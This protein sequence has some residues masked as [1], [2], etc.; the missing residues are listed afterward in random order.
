MKLRFFV[1]HILPLLCVS[2]RPWNYTYLPS[3][4]DTEQVSK[5]QLWKNTWGRKD[6]FGN[7]TAEGLRIHGPRPRRGHT[8]VVI[9]TYLVMFGGRD[10]NLPREL[11]VPKTYNVKDINGV[12]EFTTYDKKPVSACLDTQGL[13]YSAAERASCTGNETRITIGR[14]YNDVWAYNMNCTRFFDGPCEGSGWEIW[15]PGSPNGG[16]SMEMGVL[17]CPMPSE[18][19][20]HKAVYF[21]DGVMYMYGGFSPRCG[22]YCDDLWMFDIYIK[23]WQQVNKTRELSR[24]PEFGDGFGNGGPGK[25]WRFTM[26]QDRPFTAKD[27]LDYQRFIVFGGHRLWEGFSPENSEGNNWS[28]YTTRPQGGYLNDL[29]IY[30]KKLD[31]TTPVGK[32]FRLS[33]GKWTRKTG[34]EVCMADPGTS[35]TQRND[36]SCSVTWPLGRAGHS[37]ALDHERNLMWIFGGYTTYFPYLTSNAPGAGLGTQTTKE[38]GYNPYPSHTYFLNDIWNFNFS[39]GQWTQIEYEVNDDV[40]EPR[41]DHIMLLR[42]EI[43]FVHGGQGDSTFFDDIWYFNLTVNKWLKKTR[44]VYPIY[45]SN[46]T[47]DI[48]FI[49]NPANNCTHLQWPKHLERDKYYPFDILP[50]AEQ[51]HYYPD[52]EY[53]PYWGIVNK[54][55]DRN[56]HSALSFKNHPPPYTPIVPYAAKGPMQ[57]ARKFVFTFNSTVNGTLYQWCTSVRGEPTR[58][59]PF[60]GQHGRSNES[61]FIDQP[62][63]QKPDWDGCRDRADE[64]TDLPSGLQYIRPLARAAH[65]AI[66]YDGGNRQAN[67]SEEIVFFGGLAYLGEHV[68][69]HSTTHVTTISDE[70]WYFRFDICINNCSFKGDCYYG[71]CQCWEGYY[72]VDCSNKSCPGTFCYYDDF[73]HEQICSHGCQA[74]YNHTDN[75]VY[76]Q[77]IRK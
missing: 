68:V 69:N 2:W 38:T 53:G 64:R 45:P 44:S 12:L 25:R 56:D 40:P 33:K 36:I 57:Y 48:S 39:N 62:R 16:C 21:D 41:F 70:M 43:L 63:R 54:D 4:N 46:C 10:N 77:D 31:R 75:D 6:A 74:G 55:F 60:D 58:I 30:T 26:L 34:I 5:F 67:S 23:Q 28:N 35:W 18:R 13:Y 72:G 11:H 76:Q 61:I 1:I 50:A 22:D 27:G 52:P 20:N 7:L 47:D 59:R 3:V 71:F 49:E 14:F 29:W 42:G 37:A 66:L 19:W 9:G 65:Q 32:G 17:V 24:M 8:L 51:T 15:H 73:T